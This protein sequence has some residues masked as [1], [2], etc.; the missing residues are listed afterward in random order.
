MLRR[1]LCKVVGQDETQR[2]HGIAQSYPTTYLSSR[3]HFLLWTSG[4]GGA[5][6]PILVGY[7]QGVLC[8]VLQYAVYLY[9]YIHVYRRKR[10]VG[11]GG[12]T[13]TSAG[14]TLPDF[15]EVALRRHRIS[16]CLSFMAPNT[17]VTL[18][19][20]LSVTDDITT[21]ATT[22][23]APRLEPRNPEVPR[24]SKYRNIEI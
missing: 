10:L 17:L 19:V 12:V 16:S 9:E 13:E 24:R 14:P 1:R 3:A 6:T 22:T 4:R 18:T 21:T 5:Y 15:V 11:K 8:S 7:R 20:R 23:T 2:G